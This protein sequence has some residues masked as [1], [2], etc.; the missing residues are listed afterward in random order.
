MASKCAHGLWTPPAGREKSFHIK[1][2]TSRAWG[3][4]LTN[5]TV[6]HQAPLQRTQSLLS[7][8]P[9]LGCHPRSHMPSIKHMLLHTHTHASK[10]SRLSS[11]SP[12]ERV[13]NYK[14][15]SRRSGVLHPPQKPPWP[16]APWVWPQGDAEMELSAWVLR[17]HSG[18]K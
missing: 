13:A 18:C 8:L 14:P 11:I 6:T 5:R 4:V 2:I 7:R 17:W 12:T 1:A 3:A 15:Y 10:P 16:A 9:K